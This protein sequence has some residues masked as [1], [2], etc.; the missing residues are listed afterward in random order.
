MKLPNPL[1]INLDRLRSDHFELSE[2]GLNEEDRGIYR[3]AFSDADMEARRW[4]MRK[5]EGIGIEPHMDGAAN[6]HGLLKHPDT[7]KRFV[8]GSHIDTVPCAG[9]LDGALGV[10]VALESLRCIQESGTNTGQGI[11]IVAFSDEEGRFGGMFGSEAYCG[12]ITPESLQYYSD[13]EDRTLAEAMTAQG[14]DPLKALEAKRDADLI[15]GYLEVHIEQGPVLDKQRK[16]VG[17]VETITGLFKWLV[18]IRGEANHAG[19]TPMQMRRDAFLGLAEFANELPRILEENGSDHSRATIGKAQILPGAPNTVPGLVEFTLDVRDPSADN[20]DEL[21]SAL[22]KALS[23]IARRRDLMFDFEEQSF[24]QPVSCDEGIVSVLL[25]QAG[26]LELDYLQMPS[27]AAHDA[28]M[29][30]SIAPIGMIF[31]P[32]K[33]GQSHSPAEWTDWDHIEAGANLA[34]NTLTQLSK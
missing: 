27:G 4:L 28:Q 15:T 17:I 12:A 5:L 16:Q 32:S 25:G 24:I 6:V 30:A 20:L 2:I 34:L 8:I 11:E 26:E 18:R 14:L 19:T 7:D 31:V 22:R 21:G 29:V 3:T 23:A 33:D 1:L 10:L 13:L 9:T